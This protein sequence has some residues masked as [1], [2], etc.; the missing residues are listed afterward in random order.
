MGHAGRDEL[1]DI[2]DV[3]T[4]LRRLPDVVE[5]SP[6]VF[7]L[8]REPFLHFHTRAGERCTDAKAG[9]TWG[10]R[11]PLPI[12]AGARQKAAFLKQVR[13]RHAARW[14]SHRAE[15]SNSCTTT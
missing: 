9:D 6:G 3:L 11:I 15:R 14:A 1:R 8:R 7:Y 12:G 10:P 13:A 5:R 4:A 2:A